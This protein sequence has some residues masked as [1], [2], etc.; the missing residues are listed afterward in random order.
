L[1]NRGVRVV[2]IKPGPTM[3]PMTEGLK[4][5]FMITAEESANQIFRA[6]RSGR[7]NA[8]VP[9]IWWPIMTIIRMIPSFLFRGKNI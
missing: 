3:T 6:I 1:G 7:K 8:Y 9:I 2:T 5:P 4:M